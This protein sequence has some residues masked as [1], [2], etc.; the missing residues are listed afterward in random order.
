MKN[1]DGYPSILL[2][3]CIPIFI[4]HNTSVFAGKDASFGLT[5]LNEVGVSKVLEAVCSVK[6]ITTSGLEPATKTFSRQA[7]LRLLSAQRLL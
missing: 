1:E 3:V 2:R 5:R 6:Q 4:P 7:A